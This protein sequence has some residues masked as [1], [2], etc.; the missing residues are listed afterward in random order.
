VVTGTTEWFNNVY[1]PQLK[2]S[3]S[4]SIMLTVVPDHPKCLGKSP[5]VTAQVTK[6]SKFELIS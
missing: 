6:I 4:S 1:V 5:I 3:I 2:T